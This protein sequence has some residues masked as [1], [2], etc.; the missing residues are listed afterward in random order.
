MD[1]HKKVLTTGRDMSLWIAIRLWQGHGKANVQH[2]YK[3]IIKLIFKLTKRQRV[4][5]ELL[6][7]ATLV[8]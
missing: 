8:P 6:W 7:S 5:Y 1:Y 2:P 3:N 4:L